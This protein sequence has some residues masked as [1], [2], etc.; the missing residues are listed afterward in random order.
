MNRLRCSG[1]GWVNLTTFNI[2]L[3]GKGLNV[4]VIKCSGH[5]WVNQITLHIPWVA[6]D[7]TIDI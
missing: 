6:K 5:E 2:F 7:E 4:T 1:H 3:V